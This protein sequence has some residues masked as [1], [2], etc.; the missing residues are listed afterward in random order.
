M[1]KK[2]SDKLSLPTPEELVSQ[3]NPSDM[4]KLA[5]AQSAASNPFGAIQARPGMPQN[6]IRAP[7]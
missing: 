2:A 3:C 4:R 7:A 6:G 1:I 5:Q